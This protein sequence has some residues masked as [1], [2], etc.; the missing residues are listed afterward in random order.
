MDKIYT[1]F[2]KQSTISELMNAPWRAESKKE[3]YV[4]RGAYM[5]CTMGTHEEVLNQ[6][7]PNGVYINE[8][9][10]MTVKDCVTSKSEE[11][12]FRGFPIEELKG[13]MDGN[14]Y[15]FGFCRSPQ[16]PMKIAHVATGDSGPSY[17]YNYDPDT[18]V[19]PYGEEHKIFPCVPKLIPHLKV[20]PIGVDEGV[21][22]FPNLVDIMSSLAKLSEGV[23]W[24]N[25]SSNVMIDGV[26]ALTTKSCLT[27]KYGGKIQ[28]LTNGMEPTPPE[29]LER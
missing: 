13:E 4:T 3:T 10:M 17:I 23:E 26:P 28:I 27:C 14:F 15:S 19:L 24:D 29:F 5:Y 16:N 1:S 6:L 9:K 2:L 25:G 11:K 21:N 12:T 20:G 8:N 22:R 18:K 7:E